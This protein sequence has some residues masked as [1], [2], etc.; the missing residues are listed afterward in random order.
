M[1]IQT[2]KIR[3]AGQPLPM[4]G[5]SLELLTQQGDI[6]V[7]IHIFL[8]MYPCISICVSMYFNVLMNVFLV[9]NLCIS[10]CLSMYLFLLRNVF[11]F[12]SPISWLV[13]S[14]LSCQN[15]SLEVK[16]IGWNYLL[17]VFDKTNRKVS[18]VV[19]SFHPS[20][21]RSICQFLGKAQVP[22]KSFYVGNKSHC[23]MSHWKKAQ[24]VFFIQNIG[25]NLKKVFMSETK[26]TAGCHI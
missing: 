26:L 24:Q 7:V 6:N 25:E 8:F 5:G 23:W 21:K 22:K 9:V 17:G 18:P 11:R 15:R 13:C 20:S 4:S 12:V 10:Y 3:R 1:I 19:P 2:I 14:P 16:G